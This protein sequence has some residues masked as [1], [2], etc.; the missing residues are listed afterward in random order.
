MD[1]P[2]RICNPDVVTAS[3]QKAL[4]HN[5]PALVVKWERFAIL[6]GFDGLE[7]Q[8]ACT[9]LATYYDEAAQVML[10]SMSIS[11]LDSMG[12]FEA[13]AFPMIRKAFVFNILTQESFGHVLNR[14]Y[15]LTS[16][17]E[18]RDTTGFPVHFDMEK[19]VVDTVMETIA[20]EFLTPEAYQIYLYER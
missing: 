19:H 4:E 3:Y 9:A 7:K 12:I 11:G 1:T 17:Y 6:N 8:K 15:Q 14:M 2:N 18:G 13:I 5:G 20:R 10:K 16:V